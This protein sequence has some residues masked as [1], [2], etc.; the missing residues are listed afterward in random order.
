[1]GS[2]VLLAAWKQNMTKDAA[3]AAAKQPE[4]VAEARPHHAATTAIGT[5][6]ALR[7]I[8]L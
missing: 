6:L 4:P 3:A 5:V 8:S 7:S 1:M 2:G